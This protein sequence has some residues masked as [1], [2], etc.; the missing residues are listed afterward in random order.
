MIMIRFPKS[1]TPR[2][3]VFLIDLFI[4]AISISLAFL[5]RF[6][7]DIP[8]P[9][10]DSLNF[11]IPFVLF[12]R[13]ITFLI[14]RTY[15]G[16]I[17]YSGAKDTE[18]IFIVAITG[19]LLFVVINILN[20]YLINEAFIIPFSII[21]IDFL[22]TIFLMA[23]F[24]LSTKIVYQELYNPSKE[25]TGVIIYGADQFGVITKRTL[26][27][28]AESKH[29]VLAFLDINHANIGKKLEGVT[30]FHPQY[31]DSLIEKNDVE[32]LIIAK[33]NIQ[34]EE[35]QVIIEQCLQNNIKVL[36]LPDVNTWINGELSFNQIKEIKIED[37]LERP[38]IILDIHKIKKKL[39]NKC[40]L[41]TGAA[42]SIGSEIVRQL[43]AFN[44]SKIIL[45]DQAESPLYD[46]ELDLQEKFNF[47]NFDIVIGNI[48]D[49]Y[50]IHKLFEVYQPVIVFHAAA[51]KHVPM[52]ESNP[53]EAL[54]TNIMGTK[55][56][57][58]IAHAF[59]VE[60]FVMVSTDKAVNPTNVMGA[61]KRIAEIYVQAF[62]Q[63]SNT[64]FIT[65]RF[66][67]VLGSNGS[68]I[69]RFKK[70]IDKG[71]PVTV[72]H[73]EVTRYFMTIPEACQLVLEAGAISKGGEIFLFDMGKSVKIIDLAKKMIK[74]SGLEI[75]KD[76]Q[77]KYTGLR[78][79]EKLYEELLN[80][81]E[82]TRPTHHSKI[83]VAQ[84]RSYDFEQVKWDIQQ[85]IFLQKDHNNMEI[86]RRMKEIVPEFKSHNSVYEELDINFQDQENDE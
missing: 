2:W 5:L 37:L 62:N 39:L 6:N 86:V 31:L 78:P 29:K 35:K 77:I 16:I 28:D 10:F 23:S 1:Y 22:T 25:K 43:I 13:S 41:V 33:E 56:L 38:P 55:I 85:L 50:R 81:K 36:T 7:F 52:M 3:I 34:S 80:D 76:I 75:G 18:R 83:M 45:F 60:Q 30:I 12:I 19:S 53:T 66:G 26:D 40:I 65:T 8:Q 51:Y 54:R 4:C 14:F 32:K 84:V 82:N 44:P 61:S 67:N 21:A 72:T 46:M 59:K 68:V 74:L 57:A 69:L 27:R 47:Y 17:R 63:V 48:A 42:G 15:A 70:Q 11:I 58:D 20:Y 49:E 9:Y 79:G 73:P 71:G 24:R 64:N